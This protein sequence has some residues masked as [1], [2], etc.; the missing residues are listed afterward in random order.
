[1]SLFA[2]VKKVLTPQR[3]ET[4]S[5]FA[6]D[7][8]L[9]IYIKIPDSICS[10]LGRLRAPVSRYLTLIRWSNHHVAARR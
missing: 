1:M 10:K 7:P 8:E 6:L 2:K 9:F 3:P 4:V 5:A